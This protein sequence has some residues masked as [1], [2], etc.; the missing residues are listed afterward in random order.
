MKQVFAGIVLLLIAYMVVRANDQY[1]EQ[2]N[3]NVFVAIY[4]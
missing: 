2:T 4:K 1:A 3:R